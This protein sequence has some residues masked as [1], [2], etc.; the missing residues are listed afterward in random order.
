MLSM[1]KKFNWMLDPL[2]RLLEEDYTCFIYTRAWIS[3]AERS[4]V[5]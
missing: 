1:I 3:S 2:E 5:A 4:N